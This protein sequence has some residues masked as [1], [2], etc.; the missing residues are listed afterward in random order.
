MKKALFKGTVQ[1]ILDL[2]VLLI[3]TYQVFHHNT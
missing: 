2:R 1:F 3:L